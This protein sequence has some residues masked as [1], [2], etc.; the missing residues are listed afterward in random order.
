MRALALIRT[1]RRLQILARVRLGGNLRLLH[2][3]EQLLQ[4]VSGHDARPCRA[5]RFRFRFAGLTAI[6]TGQKAQAFEQR[7]SARY[8]AAA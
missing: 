2:L 7:H 8:L 4:R 6:E 5:H 1:Q 3:L